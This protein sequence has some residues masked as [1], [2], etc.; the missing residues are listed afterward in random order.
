MQKAV[1]GLALCGLLTVVAASSAQEWTRF[2]GPNGQGAVEG[3]D[4]P[5]TWSESDY[6]WKTKLPG[7]GHS[8]PVVWGNRVFLLSA[9]P[10]TAERYVLAIDTQSGAI[11]WNKNYP[12]EPHRLHAR[13][14]YASCTP[15]VDAEH[16]YVAWSTP[17]QTLLKAFDHNGNEV[18]SNDLGRWQSQHGFG[19]SPILY[20]NMVIL[21]NSQ[22]ANQLEEGEKPGESFMMAF[23]RKTG[24]EIWRTPRASVNV[25]Y[26]VPC[27]YQPENGPA[28]LI[29]ASTADGMFSLDP[30]TGKENWRFVAF[31][32]RVVSSPI[33]AGGLI[34]GS[35]GSGG[36]GN[37]VAAIKP[38]KSPELA[39]QVKT[40]AP[41]V[42]TMV[43]KDDLIFLWYDKGI[44]SCLDAA[45]GNVHWRERIGGDFSGSPIRVGDKLYCLDGDGTVVVLKADK[46]FE[47]IGRNPLGEDSRSTPAVA[48]GRIYFRTYSHLISLGG[49][50]T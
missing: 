38:G 28:E 9:D 6:N 10:E 42:P 13:S 45:T 4:L 33:L 31:D 27:I 19:T 20:K 3:V 25:C 7:I 40:Q 41:Y 48:N 37:S 12:S 22:Q 14:S 36:G 46:T 34:F 8:S 47:Q 21:H 15:A 35:T 23:D 44:V 32:K 50:S 43:A 26:C 49:K 1:F 29:C 39:Y 5:G 11:V 2:H 17:K 24:A 30:E 18:W 16:V